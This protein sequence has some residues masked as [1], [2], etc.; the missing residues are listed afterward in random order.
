VLSLRPEKQI[1]N[2]IEDPYFQRY[3]LI[4]TVFRFCAFLGWLELYRQEVTFLHSGD[5]RHSKELD[6]AIGL[7]RGDLADGQLNM[8]DDWTD[9]R[10]TL[11]FRE[12]LRAI[13]EAM[14]ETRGTSRTVMGYGGFCEQVDASVPSPTKT[15][16]AV[17]M[18]FL[19][20]LE[21]DRRDFRQTR[22]KRLLVHLVA[23]V[24]LLGETEIEKHLLDARTKWEAAVR[25]SAEPDAVADGGA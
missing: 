10:D 5:N 14:V 16:A 9:W 7:I 17:V 6:Q 23:L 3:K 24:E 21:V 20:D 15:W 22:L 12:E 1:D 13:G 11:I 19:L 2:S 18:N 8:A 25:G 4:S